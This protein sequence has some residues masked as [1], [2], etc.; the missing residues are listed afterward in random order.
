M[1]GVI[2]SSITR[3]NREIY[4][5]VVDHLINGRQRERHVGALSDREACRSRE[6]RSGRKVATYG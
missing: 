2:L 1:T 4:Q 6:P 3:R 5:L